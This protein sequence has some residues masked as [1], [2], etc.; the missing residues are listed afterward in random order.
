MTEQTEEKK[1]TGDAKRVHTYPLIRVSAE[2]TYAV[3]IL[4]DLYEDV[5]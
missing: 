1:D 3:V 4:T 5:Y 2:L